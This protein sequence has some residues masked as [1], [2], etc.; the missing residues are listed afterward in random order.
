MTKPTKERLLDA[1]ERL[2]AANGIDGT[3]IRAITDAA[4][5]NVAAV[6]FHF[7]GKSGLIREM[8]ARRL[9]P[10]AERRL[11]LLKALQSD[12]RTA[13]AGELLD[14]FMT[15]LLELMSKADPNTQ[16]FAKLFARTVVEPT[17][18]IKEIF[19]GEL[20]AY[21]ET[22][23]NAF[24]KALPHLSRLELVLRLDFAIGAIA[25]ALSDQTRLAALGATPDPKRTH[26]SLRAFLIA[27]LE[28]PAFS[29]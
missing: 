26:A 25:H 24:E 19:G 12:E 14:A 2:C 9:V 15:P 11:E 29:E 4:G 3:S 20:T 7:D 10:L 18:A 1:A 27:G 6:N 23:L 13:N 17:D 16:A 28:A 22:F 21:S 5:A 8:F